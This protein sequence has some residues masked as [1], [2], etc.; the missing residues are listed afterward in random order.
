MDA[1]VASIFDEQEVRPA[2]GLISLRRLAA[3]NFPDALF[4]LGPIHCC[5][6]GWKPLCEL[7]PNIGVALWESSNQR[8][9]LKKGARI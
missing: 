6:A 9:I 2:I 7:C 5:V 8:A 1:I 3:G 4:S